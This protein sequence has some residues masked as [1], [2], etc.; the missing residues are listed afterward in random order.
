MSTIVK[1]LMR[2][3]SANDNAGLSSLARRRCQI[4]T[5]RL[6]N[7]TIAMNAAKFLIF[8]KIQFTGRRLVGSGFR[9]QAIT[10]KTGS[11]IL[12]VS[13]ANLK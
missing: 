13:R 2:A 8:T 7:A 3:A 1:A 11:G 5:P 6:P 4:V 10:L 12:G 9:N